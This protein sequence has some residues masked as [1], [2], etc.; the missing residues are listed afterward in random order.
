MRIKYFFTPSSKYTIIAYKKSSVNLNNSKNEFLS[1]ILSYCS[2]VSQASSS[3][4]LSQNIFLK[5]ICRPTNDYSN[6]FWWPI[7]KIVLE[8][9]ASWWLKPNR[10]DFIILLGG[11]EAMSKYFQL[12]N[13]NTHFRQC[14]IHGQCSCRADRL[15]GTELKIVFTLTIE[16]MTS[17]IRRSRK[18]CHFNDRMSL[19]ELLVIVSYIMYHCFLR[20][21]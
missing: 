11:I 18:C 8:T 6:N 9:N 4:A 20:I 2:L 17:S 1:L 15:L 7:R 19:L 16:L 10:I 13:W 3:K 5:S 14:N 21:C 12:I